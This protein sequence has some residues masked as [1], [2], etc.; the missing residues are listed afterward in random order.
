M[1]EDV[2]SRVAHGLGDTPGHLG[3]GH[4]EAGMNR[5][6]DHVHHGECFVV[7]VEPPIFEYVDFRRLEDADVAVSFLQRIDLLVLLLEL[8]WLHSVHR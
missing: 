1:G 3:A 7:E 8:G 5:D 4:V 2:R 6:H